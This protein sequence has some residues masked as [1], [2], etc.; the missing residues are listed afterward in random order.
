MPCGLTDREAEVLRLIASGNTNKEI[1]DT[2]F[3]SSKTVSRHLSNIFAKIN[4]STRAA[5]TA[6]A[7]ENGLNG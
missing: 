5:A 2:L 6:F 3:L 4:V 1:A 7:F